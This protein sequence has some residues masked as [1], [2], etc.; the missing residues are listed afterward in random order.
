MKLLFEI[1]FEELPVSEI[2]IAVK[3]ISNNIKKYLDDLKIYADNIRVF[4]TPRRLVLSID[5]LSP[6][7]CDS[8]V[9]ILGPKEEEAFDSEG[10]LTLVGQKFLDK[11][12]ADPGCGFIK[13]TEK[14]SVFAIKIHSQGYTTKEIIRNLLPRIIFQIPFTKTMHW[15]MSKTRFP[16]PIRWIMCLLDNEIIPFQIAGINSS[17]KTCGHRFM[18]PNFQEV[19]QENYFEFLEKNYVIIDGEKRK[20]IILEK[21]Q[22]LA[23]LVNGK[24]INDELLLETVSNMVEY[25][26]PILS[27]F[28]PEYLAVPQEILICEM[29]EHQKY[30]AILDK[31]GNLMPHFIV[32]L[33]SKPSNDKKLSVGNAKVL[34]AR[35]EDGLFYYQEDLKRK[36]EDFIDNP[37][38]QLIRWATLLSD[39][40]KLKRAAYLSKADLNSGIV[41]QFPEL[42]GIMGGIYA[43][44]SGESREIAQ[45]I[46][47]QYLPRHAKDKIPSTILGVYLS[48]ANRLMLLHS[49]KL[50]KGNAD[51]FGLRRAAI[52]SVR[53]I[54]ECKLSISLNSIISNKEIL[55][56][57]I[58]RAHKIFSESYSIS[59]IEASLPADYDLYKWQCR[60][61]TLQNFDHSAILNS[62]KR[63]N[64]IFLKNTY[65]NMQLDF[66]QSQLK[67]EIE[68][69]INRAI[70]EIDLSENFEDILHKLTCISLMID[71]FFAQIL[72]ISEDVSLRN[73]RLALLKKVLNKISCVADF[74]K[75]TN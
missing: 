55:E 63:I 37:P 58:Q 20:A 22:E 36:I 3:F 14:K 43:L 40:S 16:R 53:L 50:P 6:R 27:H 4:C 35:F 73:T 57:I 62:F 19:T 7:Q 25:P 54:L 65:T 39:N 41:T 29:R 13:K 28:N 51:P 72:V 75:I 38:E 66:N 64:N 46:K 8:V 31:N 12:K 2:K 67:E 49:R 69:K 33:G 70:D 26:W 30:L 61:Q 74:S 24:I 68:F 23:Q 32:I 47:E 15:E 1:G 17:N 21:V 44:H 71:Q 18:S 45:A 10:Q 11:Y 56:F 48:L 59:I 9:E 52:G 60:I 34:K 42:Q 5:G